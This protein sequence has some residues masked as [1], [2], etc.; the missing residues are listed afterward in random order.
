MVLHKDAGPLAH[1][2]RVEHGSDDY[3]GRSDRIKATKMGCTVTRTEWHIKV[4][5]ITAD[6]DFRN[7]MSKFNWPQTAD[8][9]NE[10][11]ENKTKNYISMNIR[12]KLKQREVVWCSN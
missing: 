3:K 5:P 12:E 10:L 7:E 9:L 8:K 11:V 4:T 6:D 2:T 1:A